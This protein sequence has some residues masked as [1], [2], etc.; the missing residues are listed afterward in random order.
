MLMISNPYIPVRIYWDQSAVAFC[1][2][3]LI[4]LLLCVC[5]YVCVCLCYAVIEI[6]AFD[7]ICRILHS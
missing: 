7:R 6:N 4:L 5:V 2:S 1:A 3:E